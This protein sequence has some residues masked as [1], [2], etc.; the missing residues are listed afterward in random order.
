MADRLVD[1]QRDLLAVQHDRAAPCG[2][3]GA[4]RAARPPPRPRAGRGR[5]RSRASDVLPAR[6]GASAAAVGGRVGAHRS[7]SVGDRDRR[8]PAPHSVIVCVQA[9]PSVL[10]RTPSLTPPRR[11]PAPSCARC[12]R[13]RRCA[14]RLG[15]HSSSSLSSSSARTGRARRRD[16]QCPPAGATAPAAPGRGRPAGRGGDLQRAGQRRRAPA[17]VTSRVAAKPQP[18]PTRTRTP[19]PS[20]LELSDRP[21]S[22]RRGRRP[23]SLRVRRAAPRRTA[24][25]PGGVIHEIGEQVEH[26]RLASPY[27]EAHPQR[28]AAPGAGRRVVALRG[29]AGAA[30]AAP[31]LPGWLA[32]QEPV[33]VGAQV[34]VMEPACCGRSCRSRRSWRRRDRVAGL[35][36]RP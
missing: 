17:R 26:R 16:A 11:Q 31:R 20:R 9:A 35:P 13:R 32:A 2:H 18:P 5:R 27:E 23:S 36:P 33:P 19:M 29:R 8:M 34:R 14:A 24:Q 21:R 10:T 4:R 25:R 22:G 1:L 28:D 12:A 15:G 30:A 7:S 3:G 6:P